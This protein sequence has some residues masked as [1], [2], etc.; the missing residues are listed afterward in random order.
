MEIRTTRAFDR[1]Y[2]NL[3]EE[4]K[5]RANKQF[6]FLLQD[7]QHPSLRAKKLKSREDIW[8]AR[9]TRNYRFTFQIISDTYI[10]RRIGKHEDV[11]RKP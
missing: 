6:S 7:P 2:R 4:V 11:L 8:E 1:D 9:V 3:P 5:R 10:L